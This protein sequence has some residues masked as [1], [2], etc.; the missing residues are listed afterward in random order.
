MTLEYKWVSG[1]SMWGMLSQHAWHSGTINNAV[2]NA[3]N[4]SQYTSSLELCVDHF[5]SILEKQ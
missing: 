5:I 4:L 3:K 1:M 2:P